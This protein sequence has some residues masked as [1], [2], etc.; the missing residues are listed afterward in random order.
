[1]A[2]R[3]KAVPRANA[4][5]SQ[6]HSL[7]DDHGQNL[8][9]ADPCLPRYSLSDAPLLSPKTVDPEGNYDPISAAVDKLL[10]RRQSAVAGPS[11]GLSDAHGPTM[12]DDNSLSGFSANA[13][14]S[15]VSGESSEY[16]ESG[17][18][19]EVERNMVTPVPETNPSL[20]PATYQPYQ[21]GQLLP[22]VFTGET[23]KLEEPE[24]PPPP[25]TADPFSDSDPRASHQEYHDYTPIHYEGPEYAQHT[26][27]RPITS[28]SYH[29]AFIPSL[30]YD[31]SFSQDPIIDHFQHDTEAY[32]SGN[33][34]RVSFNPPRSRSPTPAVDDED[35]HIVGNDGV[36]YTGYPQNTYPSDLSPFYSEKLTDEHG[37]FIHPQ[38]AQ[39]L[40]YEPHSEKTPVSSLH[41]AD[42]ETPLETL[43]F[44]PAPTGRILRRHKSKKRVQL[45]NGNLVV[46]IPVPPN[47]VLPRRGDD[48]TLKTRYTA[49]TCDPDEFEKKGFFL[50]QN[51]T[52]R[53]TEL[54]IV[55]TLYNVGFPFHLVRF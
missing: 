47:I 41:S 55:V 25:D 6:N 34:R 9:M 1:M 28:N 10:E 31:Q 27:E 32:S 2:T 53:R 13:R 16:S 8:T 40:H 30:T 46:D 37:N 26:P 5:S 49:V 50:R 45:T 39:D 42:P 14:A 22:T 48:E 33:Y 23:L 7:V 51:E 21:P 4:H 19:D 12:A 18:E 17:E 38:Y 20:L 15:T 11:D 3:R 36:H 43:H 54:F 29:S 24:H 44:G 35:Y 52:G